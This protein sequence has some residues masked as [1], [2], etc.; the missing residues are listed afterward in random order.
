MI[1]PSVHVRDKVYKSLLDPRFPSYF[2]SRY[3][4]ENNSKVTRGLQ[5]T[6]LFNESYSVNKIFCRE[7]VCMCCYIVN[8][9][10]VV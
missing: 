7:D 5:M 4:S 10:D 9:T 3:A 1:H 8:N 2:V 6:Q